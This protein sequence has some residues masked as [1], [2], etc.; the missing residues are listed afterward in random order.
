MN[1]MRSGRLYMFLNERTND[2]DHGSEYHISL[3]PLFF[4]LAL[5]RATPHSLCCPDDKSAVL[6]PDGHCRDSIPP[7]RR[8][9]STPSFAFCFLLQCQ[10]SSSY[11][12]LIIVGITTSAIKQENLTQIKVSFAHSR[13]HCSN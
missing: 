11:S 4:L 5:C 10:L 12:I 1:H 7:S 2:G 13:C 6:L 3:P 9:Y 8:Q